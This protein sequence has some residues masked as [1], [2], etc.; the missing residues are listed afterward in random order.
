[1]AAN[2]FTPTTRAL[3]T[4]RDVER[5]VRCGVYVGP[6]MNAH[7]RK[8]RSQGGMGT[9]SNGVLLCGSGTT[10]CHGWAHSNV[11]KAREAGLIVPS[12]DDPASVPVVTWRGAMLLDDEGNIA[13]AA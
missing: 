12:W 2:D 11:K 1:M 9:P 4:A 5:C 7:H 3:I 10:R 6:G 8:L 13:P